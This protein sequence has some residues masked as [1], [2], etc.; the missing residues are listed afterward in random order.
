MIKKTSL[1]VV[2]GFI[3]VITLIIIGIFTASIS[4]AAILSLTADKTSV[5]IGD[6]FEVDI[7]IDTENVG[8]NAAQATL[9]FPSNILSVTGINRANSVFSFW[10]QEP[11]YSNEKGQVTFIGGSTSGF[12]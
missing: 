11:D 6:T 5:K 4:H 3:T 8:I 1:F 12:T 9:Q 7:K 2:S 10:L